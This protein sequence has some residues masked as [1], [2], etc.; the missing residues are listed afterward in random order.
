MKRVYLALLLALP[1]LTRAQGVGIGTPAPAPSAVLDVVSDTQ[2]VLLPRLTAAQRDGI[3]APA[4]GLLVFQTDGTVGLY[5]FDGVV[6]LNLTSGRVPDA[7][8]AAPTVSTLAGQALLTG[9]V[10]GTGAAARFNTPG[11]V[12]VGTDGTVYVADYTNNAVRKVT[13]AGVVT[14]LVAGLN[15]PRAVAVDAAGTLYVTDTNN[16]VIRQISPAGVVSTLAG[17][18]GV[19][20]SA[21]GTG[22]AARFFI[23][24]GVAVDAGGTVYVADTG[25]RTIRVIAPGGVVTTLAGLAGVQGSANGTGAA[26]RFFTPFGIAVDAAGT[27]YVGDFGDHTIRQITPAGA[28]TVLAG[29][30]GAIGSADGP[31]LA[32]RFSYP[33]GVALGPD[34]SLY[35]ADGGNATVRKISPGGVVTTL[36]GQ[37]GTGGSTDGPAPAARF[38]SPFGVAVDAAGTV[39]VGDISNHNIRVIR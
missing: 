2:G 33:A 18:V 8:G 6:W 31:A 23:P 9:L 19:Q 21:N 1:L 5:Y 38:S 11:G 13:P 32:A 16:H 22:T 36:A 20:G 39:Y 15:R 29:A 37:A 35:V 24:S 10:N 27:V 14:T 7:A 34:G 28:A 30:F 25:N 4:A 26:A 17:Q 12:A 3:A